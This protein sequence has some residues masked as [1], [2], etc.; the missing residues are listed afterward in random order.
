MFTKIYLNLA[1]IILNMAQ[2]DISVEE[3]LRTLY[4]LQLIDSIIDDIRSIID[5]IPLQVKALENEVENIQKKYQDIREEIKEYDRAIQQEKDDIKEHETY[6]KK[7][8][9]KKYKGHNNIE[10]LDKEIE[11]KELEI[12]LCHKKWKKIKSKKDKK[13]IF[14]ANFADLYEK[15][16]EYLSIKKKEFEK[17]LEI[18]EKKKSF[19]LKKAY[20]FSKKIEPRLLQIYSRTR[21]RTKLAVVA[22]QKGA[23]IGSFFT[24]PIQ[25]CLDIAQRNMIV[26]DE[27]SGRILIDPVLAAEEAIKIFTNYKTK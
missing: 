16:K 15:K 6:I 10:S 13:T 11:F 14:Y 8:D 18:Q 2:Q 19:L 26:M 5:G 22:I 4:D 17:I 20:T 23:P 3:K 12:E 27:H 1:E 7:Y 9:Y 24:I 25:K 21:A